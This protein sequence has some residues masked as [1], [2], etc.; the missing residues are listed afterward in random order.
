[1]KR[2]LALLL[3][4]TCMLGVLAA[5]DDEPA[6]TPPAPDTPPSTDNTPTTPTTPSEPVDTTI[7]S[8]HLAQYTIVYPQDASDSLKII[9]ARLK[10]TIDSLLVNGDSIAAIPDNET[11]KTGYEILVG[12]TNRDL[13]KAYYAEGA[14]AEFA[15]R[16]ADQTILLAGHTDALL[17]KAV[18]YFEDTYLAN[19]VNC[20]MAV[21]QNYAGSFDKAFE[22]SPAT[23]S[24]IK[25]VC[26]TQEMASLG[27]AVSEKIKDV[28]GVTLSWAIAADEFNA[29]TYEIMIGSYDF[30]EIKDIKSSLWFDGYYVVVRDNKIVITATTEND[31][32]KAIE[33]L[34]EMLSANQLTGTKNVVIPS[35]NKMREVS[36]EV[37]QGIPGA[38]IL[39][40]GVFPGGDGSYTAVFWDLP[41]DTLFKEYCQTLAEEGLTLYSSTNFDGEVTIEPDPEDPDA[42]P[43]I[44]P[45]KNSF[46]T[47]IT[48]TQTVNVEYHSNAKSRDTEDGTPTAG[49]MYISVTPRDGLTLPRQSAPEF[50]PVDSEQYPVILTQLGTYEHHPTEHAMCYILRLADGSFIIYDTSYG[51]PV[52]NK[53]VGDEIYDVLYK[54]APD[55]NNIVISAIFISHPHGD[56]MGGFVQF[57]EEYASAPNIT[58]KQM[59]FNFSDDYAIGANERSYQNQ[60]YAALKRFGPKLEIVKPHTGNVLYYAG[61]KFNV[62][63]TQE[64]ILALT[65]GDG[66]KSYGNTTSIVTQMILDD[67]SSVVFGADHSAMD[68]YYQGKPFCEGALAKWYGTFLDSDVVTMFHHG[69]GGGADDYVYP[70]IS[71]SIVLWPGTWFRILGGADGSSY[72]YYLY[73][74]SYNTYFSDLEPDVWHD[75]PNANGVHGWFVAD[76]GIQILTFKNGEITVTTYETRADYHNS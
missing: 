56:H 20:R 19:V 47:Y 63:Y 33:S 53:S 23:A 42:L 76:D 66:A 38:S 14:K 4:L 57:A 17:D 3:C 24:K 45:V 71:P 28:T 72:G 35:N 61:V 44:K 13:S 67:G 68:T 22:I 36:K 46:V 75:T 70:A 8:L 74:V 6:V 40:D 43:E 5:C 65:E 62:L 27:A 34:G 31:Y 1:M 64:N 16:Y 9:V 2:L 39:P 49:R 60:V 55:P 59:V 10:T 29:D 18:R 11:S 21:V 48:D 26:Q 25:I 54:Q 37:L 30:E 69:L 12:Q 41:D 52:D 32:A 51:N 73:E 50:V 15:V 7:R 58:L